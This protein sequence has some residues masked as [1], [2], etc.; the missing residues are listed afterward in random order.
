M[1]IA[2]KLLPLARY[3]KNK[4]LF[5]TTLKAVFLTNDL[6][7]PVLEEALQFN[8]DLIISY[9]PPLFTPFKRL[10]SK[11]WKERVAVKCV[12]NKVAVFSPHTS[13]DC[14]PGGINTWLVSPYGI[15]KARPVTLSTSTIFP[16][17]F[18]HTISLTGVAVAT[19]ELQPLLAMPGI[20]VSIDTT[21]V[22]I[23]CTKD[24]L[25]DIL[26]SL[27]SSL[28]DSVRITAHTL[29]PIPATG[30]GQAITLDEPLTM[31][32]A[33]AITKK[34]LAME[35]IRLAMAN[36][37]CMDTPVRSI[38]VCAGSGVSV[39]AG[40][41]ADL[42]ITGEMSHH[43]V[44][45]FVHKGVSVILADH[46]NTERGYFIQVKEKLE[47]LLGPEV[48]ILVSQV[49]RDPLQVV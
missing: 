1:G 42:I 19:E 9:H 22:T 6:T 26:S 48:K 30:A 21:A 17:G 39:L 36:G 12:E 29:P 31:S 41:K 2:C 18:S 45:D 46:T 20:S 47:I 11:S 4:A 15:G 10:T 14:V 34:H 33:L 37:A 40:V 7:E 32:Q 28:V 13:W 23:S 24:K 16:G 38:A 25:A 3:S 5:H 27:P 8:T 35:H 44:L 49:D 43:E